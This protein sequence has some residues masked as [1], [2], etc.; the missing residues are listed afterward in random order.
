[1][2]STT[3]FVNATTHV[4]WDFVH[5]VC[6]HKYFTWTPSQF[7]LVEAASKRTGGVEFA[8]KSY[9]MHVLAPKDMYLYLRL[10]RLVHKLQNRDYIGCLMP[11]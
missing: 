4:I 5:D 10:D 8:R 6:E 1:M 3:P 9:T 11:K 7:E 2:K